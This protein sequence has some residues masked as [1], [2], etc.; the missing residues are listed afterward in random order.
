MFV[1]FILLSFTCC[2]GCWQHYLT[3]WA[4]SWNC[5]FNSCCSFY[6]IQAPDDVYYKKKLSV[7]ESY[8]WKDIQEE[9]KR[10]FDKTKPCMHCNHWT[11]RGLDDGY[12]AQQTAREETTTTIPATNYKCGSPS[13]SKLVVTEV[14]KTIKFTQ[15][16]LEAFK[17][18]EF[19]YR[20]SLYV[21]TM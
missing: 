12:K 17:S 1:M 5:L 16:M 2:V 11:I 20:T 14:I 6:P 7:C 8:W 10:E 15:C 9:N 18:C 19:V 13:K 4:I 3:T 21:W